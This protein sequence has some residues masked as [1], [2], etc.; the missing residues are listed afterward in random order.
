MCLDD[1]SAGVITFLFRFMTFQ[2]G[3]GRQTMNLNFVDIYMT[4][5]EIESPPY[6]IILSPL[7]FTSVFLLS[8]RRK[9]VTLVRLDLVL[10]ISN[11][12]C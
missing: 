10:F 5:L 9:L 11:P 7:L 4:T 1:A 2:L 12:S 3:R 8:V 6:S